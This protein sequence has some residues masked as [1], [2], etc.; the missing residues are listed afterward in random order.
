M[1]LV[2]GDEAALREALG[3]FQ[4]LGAGALVALCRERLRVLGAHGVPRGP[5]PTTA[6]NA[7]GLTL[8]EMQVLALMADGLPNAQIAAR[9]VRSEKTVDH[10]VSAILGKLGARSR[11]EA[12]ATARRMGVLGA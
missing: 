2:E 4:A 9:L 8:R 1:A 3:V 5:R 6:A 12:V 10:H 11:T 7:A